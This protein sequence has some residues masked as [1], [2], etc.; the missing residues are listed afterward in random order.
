M[1]S[2]PAWGP[3]P[4]LSPAG[5][6]HG[7]M[8]LRGSPDSLLSP[9]AIAYAD[10]TSAGLAT[11]GATST[12]HSPSGQGHGGKQLL[13]L[14]IKPPCFVYRRG[15]QVSPQATSSS[16]KPQKAVPLASQLQGSHGPHLPAM[17]PFSRVQAYLIPISSLLR[18]LP[19]S[20]DSDSLNTPY[21]DPLPGEHNHAKS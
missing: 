19:P 8:I 3:P 15:G 17:Y 4:V 16:H 9:P 10:G 20:I 5:S 7:A 2:S 14:P 12:A 6:S 18:L 21:Q 1:P 13:L 11:G